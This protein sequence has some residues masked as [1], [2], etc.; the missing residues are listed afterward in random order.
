MW[1]KLS[2]RWQLIILLSL[3]LSVVGAVTLGLTYWFDI[4]E[5]KPLALE[6]VDTLSR[7]LQHDLVKALV[8]PQADVYSDISFRLSGF[9]TLAFFQ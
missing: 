4:K 6:Q 9:E 2:I 7:A 5:R 8:N 1:H 3:V